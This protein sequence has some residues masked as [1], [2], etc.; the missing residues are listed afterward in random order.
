MAKVK[1]GLRFWVVF[2]STQEKLI[3]EKNYSCLQIL[4]LGSKYLKPRKL[5]EE[6]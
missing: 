4:K 3:N 2:I 6:I 5:R 1:E